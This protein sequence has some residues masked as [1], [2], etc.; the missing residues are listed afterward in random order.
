[1]VETEY[2]S[3]AAGNLHWSKLQITRK[4]TVSIISHTC[5][6]DGLPALNQPFLPNI[7]I[8]PRRFNCYGYFSPSPQ[9][10]H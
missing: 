5:L 1:M 3:R 2:H 9:T 6:L 10:N 8:K 7:E 4:A